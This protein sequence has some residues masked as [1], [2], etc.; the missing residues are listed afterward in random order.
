MKAQRL[1]LPHRLAVGEPVQPADAE[2]SEPTVGRDGDQV[3]LLLRRRRAEPPANYPPRRM[4]DP[5]VLRWRPEY[6]VVLSRLR[7]PMG[8]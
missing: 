8:Q 2:A 7:R 1:D 4:E 5:H 3:Q 6:T